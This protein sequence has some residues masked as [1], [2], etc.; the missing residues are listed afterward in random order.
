MLAHHWYDLARAHAAL[1][2]LTLC[3]AQLAAASRVQRRDFNAARMLSLVK[4]CTLAD[5]ALDAQVYD[6]IIR[7]R[8][9]SLHARH[10]RETCCCSLDLASVAHGALLA[11]ARSAIRRRR[12]AAQMWLRAMRDD[13]YFPSLRTCSTCV[14]E[15]CAGVTLTSLTRFCLRQAHQH[16]RFF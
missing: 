12:L 13:F 15:S 9:G 5:P 16:V 11:R 8:C 10:A 14:G 3:I 7:H 1:V 2:P 6:E 4:E